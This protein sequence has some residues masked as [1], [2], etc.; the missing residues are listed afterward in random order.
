[1]ADNSN[2]IA[3][4]LLKTNPELHNSIDGGN[5]W[6]ER[7]KVRGARVG[8]YRRYERG[9]HAANMTEQ[10]K[11]M[12][13]VRKDNDAQLKEFND[14]Y[15]RIIT[16]KMSSRLKVSEI[17]VNDEAQDWV[18]K[19]IENN[20]FESL[21]GEV[22]RGAIRDGDSYVMIDPVTLK[23]SAEPAYDGF[24][25]IVAIFDE[26]LRVPIW[27]CKIFSIADS[28]E[29]EGTTNTTVI[30]MIIV[31]QPDRIT[32]W[33]GNVNSA[34]VIQVGK[35]LVW[36][37]GV[38]PLVHFVNQ[39]DNYTQYGESEIRPAI[40]LQDLLNRTLHSMAT[41][42]EFSAYK[43]YYCIGAEL[44]VDGIVPGAVHNILL[45][46]AGG[47]A[48]T[49]YS[50]SQV[51]FLKAIKIGE[52][53]ESNMTNYTM[54]IDKITAEIS[55]ATQTP[56]YALTSTTGTLSGEAM[57][58]LEIGLIGKVKRFQREN[59]ASIRN[60]ILLSAAVQN[61]FTR[62]TNIMSKVAEVFKRFFMPSTSKAPDIDSVAVSWESPEIIDVGAQITVLV[63]MREKAPGLWDDDFYRT[64]IG[65]LLAMTS[66][67]IKEKGDEAKN[68]QSFDLLSLIRA[69]ETQTGQVTEAGTV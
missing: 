43:Q 32:F 19:I 61:E 62:P 53:N 24:S 41:A 3:E 16:T 50:E 14:N 6:R 7:V 33:K 48:I 42:S 20:E 21:G 1:M 18:N 28:T 46:D 2:L 22:F 59:N 35:E 34:G 11:R 15:M 51:E 52:F 8:T 27:A 36:P 30:M 67:E 56:I 17:V 5:G 29:L 44:D 54:Q 63:E 65:G 26:V 38:I 10:M 55:N 31:Y 64:K 69:Q 47:N 66:N 57:K 13:R 60:L 4:V 9:N 40:P 49:D 58:Q 23:W 25:G 68:A 12:L 37:V 45:K 39:K